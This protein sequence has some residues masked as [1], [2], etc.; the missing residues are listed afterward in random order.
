MPYTEISAN[1]ELGYFIECFFH[2]ETVYV[3]FT[4]HFR[5]VYLKGLKPQSTPLCSHKTIVVAIALASSTARSYS[6]IMHNIA[7]SNLA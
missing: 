1:F 7:H 5:P 2:F 4:D 3:E 6:Y